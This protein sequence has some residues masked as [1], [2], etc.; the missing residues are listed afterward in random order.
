M[1]S[2][3]YTLSRRWHSPWAASRNPSGHGPEFVS[4]RGARPAEPDSLLELAVE[5][6]PSALHY[7]HA[8]WDSVSCQTDEPWLGIDCNVA[9]HSQRVPVAQ[10][11]GVPR[12]SDCVG[13]RGRRCQEIRLGQ[14]HVDTLGQA[15]LTEPSAQLFAPQ[16]GRGDLDQ[17]AEPADG[18]ADDIAPVATHCRD[19]EKILQAEPE[20]QGELQ[21]CLFE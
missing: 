1:Y 19:R 20:L 3:L 18:P 11:F 15:P 16:V 9:P 2:Y 10:H 7:P 5:A 13:H 17:L 8:V 14:G 12:V 6:V 4:E 21:S